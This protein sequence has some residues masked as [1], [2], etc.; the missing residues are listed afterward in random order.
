LRP[1]VPAQSLSLPAATGFGIALARLL[2]EFHNPI[3]MFLYM[4]FDI[5]ALQKNFS[6][7]EIKFCIVG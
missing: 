2:I 3:N 6:I 4:K 5:V 1:I 7:Q